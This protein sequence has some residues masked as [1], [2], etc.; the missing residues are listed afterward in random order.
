MVK[1]SEWPASCYDHY[2]KSLPHYAS[3]V[4]WIIEARHVESAMKGKST[5][6][7]LNNQEINIKKWQTEEQKK[8]KL[9]LEKYGFFTLSRPVDYAHLLYDDEGKRKPAL[10]FKTAKK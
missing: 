6:N 1:N 8:T 9:P 5:V 2:I 10:R 3:V 4:D 7:L